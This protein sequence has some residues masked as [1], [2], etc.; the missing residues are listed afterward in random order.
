MVYHFEQKA[1]EEYYHE[2]AI[3]KQLLMQKTAEEFVSH[4]YVT[5]AYYFNPKQVKRPQLVRLVSRLK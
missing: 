5:E 3:D 2:I 4:L 1:N